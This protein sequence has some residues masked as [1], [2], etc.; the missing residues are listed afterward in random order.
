MKKKLSS[1]RSKSPGM[2]SI[3]GENSAMTLSW[4]SLRDVLAKDGWTQPGD[5]QVDGEGDSLIGLQ[6]YVLVRKRDRAVLPLSHLPAKM[7]LRVCV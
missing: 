2:T 5:E 4:D 6:I 3:D 1:V 7:D